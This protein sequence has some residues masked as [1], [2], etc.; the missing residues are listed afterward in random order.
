MRRH[1]KGQLAS[2]HLKHRD[3]ERINVCTRINR[4][5][6]NLFRGHIFWR[7]QHHTKICKR[8]LIEQRLTHSEISQDRITL[9]I[10]Q[11]VLGFKVPMDNPSSVGIIECRRDLL[12]NVSRA[13]WCHAPLLYGVS[14]A[15]SREQLHGEN[16]HI[17]VR[18]VFT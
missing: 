17:L 7:A 11:D 1:V 6:S 2:E 9:V 3:S 16:R 5:C 4:F 13:L 14:N 8:S 15:L 12:K 10:E 18:S